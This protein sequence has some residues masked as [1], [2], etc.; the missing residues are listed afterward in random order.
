MEQEYTKEQLINRYKGKYIKTMQT[1][2][3]IKQ[4]WVYRVTGVKSKIHE[5]YNLPEN[6]IID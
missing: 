5:N 3:Y 2:D 6:C 1:F 4:E